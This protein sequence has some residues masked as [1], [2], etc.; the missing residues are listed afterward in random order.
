MTSSS[1]AIGVVWS[2]PPERI[3]VLQTPSDDEAGV[4]GGRVPLPLPLPLTLPFLP[5]LRLAAADSPIPAATTAATA[6]ALPKRWR[7]P[8]R[9]ETV[10]RSCAMR[11]KTG[12][13]I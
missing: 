5:F 8:R 12:A 13:R 2:G 1:T 11:S 3:H 9:V 6:A 4:A 10:P 7:K